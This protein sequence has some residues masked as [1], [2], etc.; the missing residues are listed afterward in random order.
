VP[1]GTR[2]EE[3]ANVRSVEPERVFP[4]RSQEETGPFGRITHDVLATKNHRDSC[5]TSYQA[6]IHMEKAVMEVEETV[7][8]LGGASNAGFRPTLR[9]SLAVPPRQLPV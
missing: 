3:R 2:Q 1:D 9:L 4:P 5:I 8:G 7:K 6:N